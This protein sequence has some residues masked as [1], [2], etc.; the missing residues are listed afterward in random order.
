MEDEKMLYRR[1]RRIQVLKV[2]GKNMVV[3]RAWEIEW[4]WLMDF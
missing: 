3:S 4:K 1:I 2:K